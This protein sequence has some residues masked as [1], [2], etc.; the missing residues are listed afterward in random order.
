MEYTTPA[1]GFRTLYTDSKFWACSSISTTRQPSMGEDKPPVRVDYPTEIN[2]HY[3]KYM[4][5]PGEV[6]QRLY[7][8]IPSV[9]LV[10]GIT[11]S[12]VTRKCSASVDPKLQR[13][14]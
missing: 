14:C 12:G 13:R 10:D 4:C 6:I 3:C 8:H 5:V 7:S 2:Y 9:F 1:I 11:F